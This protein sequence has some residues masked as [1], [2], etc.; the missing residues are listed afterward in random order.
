M[1]SCYCSGRGTLAR[2]RLL[3]RIQEGRLGPGAPDRMGII[4]RGIM[5][6][7]LGEASEGS[8]SAHHAPMVSKQ[9]VH[10]DFLDESTVECRGGAGIR[11]FL[12]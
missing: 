7:A 11:T 3:A 4:R 8:F 10:I 1:G 2:G 9:F 12:R 5:L 6:P